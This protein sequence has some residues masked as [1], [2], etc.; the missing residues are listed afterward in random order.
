MTL[1]LGVGEC[2]CGVGCGVGIGKVLVV[3]EGLMGG[4]DVVGGFG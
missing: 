2:G 1:A 4:G 3:R